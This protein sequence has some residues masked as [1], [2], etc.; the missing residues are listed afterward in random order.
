[1]RRSIGGDSAALSDDEVKKRLGA[2]YEN[3]VLTD[4]RAILDSSL[5]RTFLINELMRLRTRI[6]HRLSDEGLSDVAA[7][8]SILNALYYRK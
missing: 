8:N 1:M 6:S 5:P 7:T 2:M 3:Y 4:P